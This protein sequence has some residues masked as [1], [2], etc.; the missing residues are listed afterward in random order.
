MCLGQNL[1]PSSLTE[2]DCLFYYIYHVASVQ[3]NKIQN[4]TKIPKDSVG[5][6]SIWANYLLYC[7]YRFYGKEGSEKDIV[8]FG[9]NPSLL[10]I[11][12]G[13]KDH[14]CLHWKQNHWER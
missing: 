7:R 2:T 1:N 11:G 4:K 3:E 8:L 13:K 10:S 9:V 12:P 14:L 6:L 5:N